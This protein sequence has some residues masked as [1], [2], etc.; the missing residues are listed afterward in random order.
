MA[1]VLGFVLA[2][3]LVLYIA[4]CYVFT[5]FITLKYERSTTE[6]KIMTIGAA[7]GVFV[8]VL[9]LSFTSVMNSAALAPAAGLSGSGVEASKSD[10]LRDDFYPYN[11]NEEEEELELDCEPFDRN[12]DGKLSKSEKANKKDYE[13]LVK[14]MKKEREKKPGLY[15]PGAQPPSSPHHQHGAAP[16]AQGQL[17]P[18]GATTPSLGWL[19]ALKK[20][21]LDFA[22]NNPAIY[23]GCWIIILATCVG[24]AYLIWKENMIPSH[25][26]LPLHPAAVA[27]AVP[28]MTQPPGPGLA[29]QP[30]AF[31]F[32]TY[33]DPNNAATPATGRDSEDSADDEDSEHEPPAAKAS[34]GQ[35]RLSRQASATSLATPQ[36]HSASGGR[37]SSTFL[38]PPVLITRATS[39]SLRRRRNSKS[40]RDGDEGDAAIQD[41]GGGHPATRA[42]RA[43]ERASKRMSLPSLSLPSA[44]TRR[45]SPLPSPRSK[46][47]ADLIHDAGLDGN[48]NG[49]GGDLYRNPPFN[50]TSTTPTAHS[51][52]PSASTP[53]RQAAKNERTKPKAK[54]GAKKEKKNRGSASDE[55]WTS[56]TASGSEREAGE[57][58]SGAGVCRGGYERRQSVGSGTERNDARPG[59]GRQ[60]N[61][62]E[63]EEQVEEEREAEVEDDD[64][65][66]Q[67]E[68]TIKEVIKESISEELGAKF[69]R[70]RERTMAELE[71]LKQRYERERHKYRNLKQTFAQRMREADEQADRAKRNEARARAELEQRLTKEKAADLDALQRSV[72]EAARK[73]EEMMHKK[74]E[75]ERARAERIKRKLAEERQRNEELNRRLDDERAKVDEITRRMDDERTKNEERLVEERTRHESEKRATEEAMKEME[76]RMK[77]AS[78]GTGEEA[79]AL[80]LYKKIDE[81]R[82]KADEWRRRLDAE[83]EKV[84]RLKGE[85]EAEKQKNHELSL[86]ID[87]MS[88]KMVLLRLHC[89]S[90]VCLANSNHNACADGDLDECDAPQL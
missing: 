50:S 62:D 31:A 5:K 89:V 8:F 48:V 57:E 32:P 75:D 18:T 36:P 80:E 63:E 25:A 19:R 83:Y 9:F 35:R 49:N 30:P 71:S 74:N 88:A 46:T 79:M 82:A 73:N 33:I 51:R 85:N 45:V 38:T 3:C 1:L 34:T 77:R 7:I 24:C 14:E 12:C 55:G 56:T 28:P 72:D 27:V 44:S 21:Y 17:P 43:E 61:E 13:K 10:H 42:T 68:D 53:K 15:H 16:V 60:R 37:S 2:T 64:D 84:E 86:Q 90:C 20:S 66:E 76:M 4:L 87:E 39:P 54:T 47:S 23:Y 6:Y 52:K 67:V 26:V 59:E 69:W 70:E 40:D 78:D 58:D 81:E 41:F 29:E 65:D 11:D 22:V